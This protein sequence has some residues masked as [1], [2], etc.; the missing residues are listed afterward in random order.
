MA[1]DV[2]ICRRNIIPAFKSTE[3]GINLISAK[4][5]NTK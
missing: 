5:A 4:T 1:D 2:Q 3:T